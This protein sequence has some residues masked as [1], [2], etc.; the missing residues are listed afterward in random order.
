[1]ASNSATTGS[2]WGFL[3]WRLAATGFSSLGYGRDQNIDPSFLSPE[4]LGN[5][6]LGDTHI[7]QLEDE[8]HLQKIGSPV[9]I[10]VSISRHRQFLL[11]RQL[12]M[13]EA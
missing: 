12:Y 7:V 2:R 11:R 1:M 9:I 6:V 3:G 4:R 8:Q 5:P 10:M 13:F